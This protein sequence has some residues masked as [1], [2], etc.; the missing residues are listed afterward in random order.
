MTNFFLKINSLSAGR[1][2]GDWHSPCY[3]ALFT[4]LMNPIQDYSNYLPF[5]YIHYLILRISYQIPY[6]EPL[7][8]LRA[9]VRAGYSS[10]FFICLFVCLSVRIT[11][12][13]LCRFSPRNTHQTGVD[14][15][16]IGFKCANFLTKATVLEK[17]RV[18]TWPIEIV[19]RV[20]P[21]LRVHMLSR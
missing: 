18:K 2:S 4:S 14:Y 10:R 1:N 17:K 12:G 5:F 7:L 20:V 19:L 13:N 8:T 21:P 16:F 3:S 15:T 6:T 9:H 11:S